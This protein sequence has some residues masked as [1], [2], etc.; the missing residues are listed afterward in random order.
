MR[1]ST[2]W[3]NNPEILLKDIDKFYPATYMTN[4]EKLNALSRFIIYGALLVSITRQ[5]QDYMLYGSLCLILIV[6]FYKQGMPDILNNP[7]IPRHVN[8]DTTKHIKEKCT[9][10]TSANPF[11]NVLMNE[12]SDKDRLPACPYEDV[13]DDI[14]DK[15]FDNIVREPYDVYNKRHNQRHFYTNANTKNPNDQKAFAEFA[16]GTPPTCKEAG[17]MCTGF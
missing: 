3:Y 5:D 8:P 15:F 16:Y 14:N 2:F 11:A 7:I 10:P 4:D 6:I 17:I 9:K 1:K 13:K 12:L